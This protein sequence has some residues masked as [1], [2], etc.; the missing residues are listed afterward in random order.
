MSIYNLQTFQSTIKKAE[1][2]DQTKTFQQTVRE[3]VWID[4]WINKLV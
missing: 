3:N 1:D 2:C 4:G